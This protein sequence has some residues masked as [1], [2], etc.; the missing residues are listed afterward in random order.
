MCNRL[1]VPLLAL[2]A[3]LFCKTARADTEEALVQ[4]CYEAVNSGSD[5]ACGLC[6]SA[7]AG[8][9]GAARTVAQINLA[10][11]EEGRGHL[12]YALENYRGARASLGPSDDRR[13]AVDERIT[14]LEG[15]IARLRLDWSQAPAGATVAVDDK[16]VDG[17]PEEMTVDPGAHRILVRVEGHQDATR[18][19]QLAEGARESIAIVPGPRL[20]SS[21]PVVTPRESGPN[22]QKIAAYT[23]GAV[24]IAGIV[25]FAITG[26]LA[27]HQQSI[28]DEFCPEGEDERRVCTDP[29]GL[30]AADTGKTLNI[31]N[32]VSLGVGVAAL[33]TGLVL[34]LTAADDDAAV[35]VDASPHG[36]WIGFRARY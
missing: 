33:A 4:A 5:A 32:G 17:R 8:T 19:I 11:C 35:S 16:P 20:S 27:L 24:G 1:Y 26:G 9:S 2:A 15:R 36:A 6:Q 18:S 34:L 22:E 21:G 29:Q 7:V 10:R 28:V 3:L 12:V 30:E 23:V 13:V 31:V 25:V 14:S